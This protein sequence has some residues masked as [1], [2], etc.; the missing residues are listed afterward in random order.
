MAVGA[1]PP[2]VVASE[3]RISNFV[4]PRSPRPHTP[5]SGAKPGIPLATIPPKLIR[6]IA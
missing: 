5:A 3:Y 4:L 6:P 2:V 1:V